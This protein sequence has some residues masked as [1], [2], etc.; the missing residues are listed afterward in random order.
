LYL[1]D[2]VTKTT[3]SSILYRFASKASLWIRQKLEDNPARPEMLI[4]EP[5]VGYRLVAKA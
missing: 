3:L 5:G 4:T 2:I 1:L